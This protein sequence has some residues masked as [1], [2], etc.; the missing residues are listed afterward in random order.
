M[1]GIALKKRKYVKKGE[2]EKENPQK[3]TATKGGKR[4]GAGRN[5]TKYSD[6]WWNIAENMAHIQC[7]RDEI[8]GCLDIDDQT[9]SVKIQEKYGFDFS[10]WR[11]KYGAN[12]KMSLRRRLYEMA[13]NPK[14]DNTQAAIWL[15]KN[16]LGMKESIGHDV[17]VKPLTFCYSLESNAE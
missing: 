11:L 7:T 4:E 16:Y 6:D 15:S 2:I 1:K 14:W 9:M 10:T 3:E 12:G 8:C 5:P 13:M 17:D